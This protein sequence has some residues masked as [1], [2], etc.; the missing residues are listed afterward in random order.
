MICRRHEPVLQYIQTAI[1]TPHGIKRITMISP[2]L[3]SEPSVYWFLTGLSLALLELAVPG[4]I[5]IFFG[6][7]AWTVSL[8]CLFYPIGINA[9]L[10]IFIVSSLL[11]VAV[12]RKQIKKKM[13]AP[14]KVA[15]DFLAEEFIGNIVTTVEDITPEKLGAVMFRGTIWKAQSEEKITAGTQVTITGKNNITLTVATIKQ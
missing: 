7:G 5:I 2:E 8:I 4:L 13:D 10:I 11:Y 15:P 9:E 6:A 3:L 1:V 12:F 14:S